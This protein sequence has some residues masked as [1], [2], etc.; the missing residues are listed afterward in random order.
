MRTKPSSQKV[1][2]FLHAGT[3]AAKANVRSVIHGDLAARREA[4]VYFYNTR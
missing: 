1:A 3:P 2:V 4:I